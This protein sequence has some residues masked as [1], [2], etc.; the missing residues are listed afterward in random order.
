M[1]GV[2]KRVVGMC[3]L[4]AV[5]GNVNRIDGRLQMTLRT[6]ALMSRHT[7]TCHRVIQTRVRSRR[8]VIG[9][10]RNREAMR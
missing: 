1:V 2:F 7:A 4:V 10:D 3:V 6:Y 9:C 5:F 8:G